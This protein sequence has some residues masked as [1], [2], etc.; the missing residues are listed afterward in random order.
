LLSSGLCFAEDGKADRQLVRT[1]MQ[2]SGLSK[3]IEQIPATM[4]ADIVRASLESDNPLSQGEIDDL[5]RKTAEAFNASIS[6][7]YC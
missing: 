7:R 1:L 3:Q 6:E 4:Q 2:K 5:S